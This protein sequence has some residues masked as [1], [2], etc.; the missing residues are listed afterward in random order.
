MNDD[1][2]KNLD[3]TATAIS[4]YLVYAWNYAATLRGFQRHTR[5]STAILERTGHFI[6]TITLAM[7]EAL[8]LKLSHCSDNRREAIGFP[9]LFKQLRAYLPEHRELIQA[10]ERRL[11]VLEI[12]KKVENWRNQII[13]HYTIT[14]GFADFYRDNVVSLDEI[15]QLLE[16]LDEILH[17]FAMQLLD[18]C[19][20]VKDLCEYAHEDVDRLVAGL[21]KEA[22]SQSSQPH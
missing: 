22:E 15:E 8:L 12:Q 5:E 14:S 21:K 18:K 9:K 3:I 19:F 17:I 20:M 1:Q 2:R 7:W 13:A 11:S 6:A 16:E 4:Q 10:Q